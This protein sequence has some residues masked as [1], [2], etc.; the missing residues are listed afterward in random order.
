[1]G[2]KIFERLKHYNVETSFEPRFI[3]ETNYIFIRF[4]FLD[5]GFSYAYTVDMERINEL[6]NV[7]LDMLLVDLFDNAL[8]RKE[9]KDGTND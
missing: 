4:H 6:S 2:C 1:M 7:E 5:S 3:D 9:E 8:K